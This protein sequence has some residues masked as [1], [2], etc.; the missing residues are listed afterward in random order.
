[1]NTALTE[2]GFKIAEEMIPM[3]QDIQLENM[4]TI[5]KTPF[6]EIFEEYVEIR[7][8]AMF[9]P[10]CFRRS[11]IE[12]EKPLVKEAYEVLG[13]DKVREMNYNQKGI[14]RELV[15]R[16]DETLDIKAFFLLDGQ[17]PKQVAI[18]KTEIKTIIQNV[19]NELGIKQKAKATDL[20]K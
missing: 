1:M 17:L 9:N 2:A 4:I 20:R 18:P 10:D 5:E 19:Y 3:G 13:A 6:K 11:R 8:G 16:M 14:K 15:K 7:A 12:V